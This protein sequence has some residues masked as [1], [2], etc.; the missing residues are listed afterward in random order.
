MIITA[1][2]DTVIELDRV[3]QTF[4]WLASPKRLAVIADS[5]HAV[6]VDPCVPIREE[7]GLTAFMEGLGLDPDARSRSSSWARTGACRPTPTPSWCGA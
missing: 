2:G 7:G 1:E 3:E 5:G 6:F 4:E